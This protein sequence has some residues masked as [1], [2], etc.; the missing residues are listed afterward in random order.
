MNQPDQNHPYDLA[1]LGA[2]PAGITAAVYS[3]RKLLDVI[4]ITSDI[5]GQMLWTSDVENY[6]GFRFITAVELIEKFKSHMEQFPVA[7]DSETEIKR[8]KKQDN[9]FEI[10]CAGDKKY[11]ASSVI[12]ATGKRYRKLNVRGED[13][14]M[15]RG[16]AYCATCDAPFFKGKDVAV[17]GGG[18]SAMTAIIDLSKFANIVYNIAIEKQYK[19]DKILV[20]KAI[21]TGRMKQFMSYKTIEIQGNQGRVSNMV[22]QSTETNEKKTIP[23]QGVFIEIGLVPNTEIVQGIVDLNQWGEVVIDDSCKTSLDG[24]FAAGDVTSVPEKQIIV[25]A[26]EGSKA[27]LA[28]H[29]YLMGLNTV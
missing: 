3:A 20:E 16:V 14:Y 8:V 15:G 4:I 25:A 19:A 5:G 18:N 26:G 2:G 13:E 22:V 11:R 29:R 1:I 12:V 6:L 7:L 21:Q 24:L 17:I 10:L 9:V 23:I 27:A 28:A